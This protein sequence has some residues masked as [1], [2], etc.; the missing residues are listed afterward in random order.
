M[1]MLSLTPMPMPMPIRRWAFV[2][3]MLLMLM[4]RLIR[5][6]TPKSY[7]RR[8]AHHRPILFVSQWNG[9]LQNLY[10]SGQSSMLQVG[11]QCCKLVFNDFF[12]F[13]RKLGFL[14]PVLKIVFGLRIASSWTFWSSQKRVSRNKC[15]QRQKVRNHVPPWTISLGLGYISY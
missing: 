2:L 9:K 3:M 1:L 11:F 13:F 7:T 10:F 5:V 14:G 12:L 6:V 15:I 4:L 8:S